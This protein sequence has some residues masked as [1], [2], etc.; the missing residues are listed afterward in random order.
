MATNQQH[1][2]GASSKESP[3]IDEI[4]TV[5]PVRPNEDVSGAGAP[6]SSK[7]KFIYHTTQNAKLMIVRPNSAADALPK[8]TAPEI[9]ESSGTAM[10]T[11]PKQLQRDPAWVDCP[12]CKRMARTKVQHKE[13]REVPSGYVQ[14]LKTMSEI[15]RRQGNDVRGLSGVLSLAALP[16]AD[17]EQDGKLDP[18]LQ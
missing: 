9:D 4:P 17:D 15:D 8:N 13:E 16:P 7:E 18:R 11:P 3:T 14:R 12:F 1:T 6:D 10:V 5:S 2:E